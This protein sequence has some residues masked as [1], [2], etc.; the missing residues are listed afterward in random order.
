MHTLFKEFRRFLYVLSHGKGR[1][2]NDKYKRNCFILDKVRF[3]TMTFIYVE[4]MNV[5]FSLGLL[6]V[7][8]FE[9]S[10]EILCQPF[11]IRESHLVSILTESEKFKTSNN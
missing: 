8:L 5:L 9:L 10:N 11:S 7:T 1:V 2:L 6:K 4:G 3:A